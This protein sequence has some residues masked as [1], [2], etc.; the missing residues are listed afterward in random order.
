MKG[1]TKRITVSVMAASLVMSSSLIALAEDAKTGTSGGAGSMEGIV[2]TNVF[3]V[4]LPTEATDAYN[5]FA[6]PQGLIRKTDAA[7]YDGAT[8]GEGNVFFENAD[9]SYSNTSDASTIVNKSSAPLSVTVKAKATAGTTNAAALATTKTFADTNT[10]LEVYLGLVDSMGTEK[11]LTGTDTSETTDAIVKAVL[12]AAPEEA[13]EYS[14][15]K[16]TSK[17]T[18]AIKSDVTG[19]KF[20]EYGFRITG[21]ANDKAAWKADTALPAVSVTW[22]VDL[23]GASDTV[24]VATP[25]QKSAPSI[26]NKVVTFSKATGAEIEVSLGSG[27][28]AA[29][30]IKSVAVVVNGTEYPWTSGDAYSLEGSTLTFTTRASLAGIAVGQSRTV[31]VTFDDDANTSE[32]LIVT[33]A[34]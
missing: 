10:D 16:D 13:Y 25:E 28:L 6:D 1:L 5:Y 22:D 30:G 19:F 21:V 24:T 31:K 29:E 3:K 18:Y 20:A 23:A 26:A 12:G 32:E 15:D 34:E 9:G 14:Y 11:A 2:E 4:D 8:F 17:Y 7:K 27:D 33:V